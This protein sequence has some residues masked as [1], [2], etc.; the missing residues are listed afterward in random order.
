MK[1]LLLTILLLMA[2]T[3]L[4][5]ND[6]HKHLLRYTLYDMLIIYYIF[7]TIN[8]WQYINIMI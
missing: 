8:A 2:S 5:A 7:V 6:L 4:R 1:L 3:P